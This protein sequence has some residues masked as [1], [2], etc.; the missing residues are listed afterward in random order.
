MYSVTKIC[1]VDHCDRAMVCKELCAPHYGRL[2]RSGTLDGKYNNYSGDLLG[3]RWR[4]VGH[5]KKGVC[6]YISNLGRCK[7]E[8]KDGIRL[9]K[10]QIV[11]G[12]YLVYKFNGIRHNA[13]R[14]IAQAFIPNPENKP[15][16]NH[17]NGIKTDNKVGNLEWC[18]NQENVDHAWRTGLMRPR[19]GISHHGAKLTE[20]Q[21]INIRHCR[22]A[23]SA[24]A[25]AERYGISPSHA[26]SI[27]RGDFWSHLWVD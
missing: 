3:E 16:I 27:M 14:L 8:A 13:H 15:Y 18:T 7:R 24:A 6:F 9:L 17:K 12:G 11:T 25:I 5:N 20:V 19:K 26:A 21:V 1:S 2:H 23:I 10:G 4:L 22:G